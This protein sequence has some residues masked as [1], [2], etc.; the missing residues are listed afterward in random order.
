LV[1][2]AINDKSVV[3]VTVVVV[4][5]ASTIVERNVVAWGAGRQ[6]ATIDGIAV[7]GPTNLRGVNGEIQHSI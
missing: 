5:V 2:N 6:V 7:V 3:M 1:R 4:N